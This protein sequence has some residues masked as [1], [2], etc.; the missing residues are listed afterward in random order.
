MNASL[1]LNTY[2]ERNMWQ[3]CVTSYT[4]NQVR[5]QRVDPKEMMFQYVAPE[6]RVEI[7]N[8]TLMVRLFAIT[9]HIAKKPSLSNV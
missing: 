8:Y 7:N 1:Y 4:D 9:S 2:L 3:R 6:K 5:G